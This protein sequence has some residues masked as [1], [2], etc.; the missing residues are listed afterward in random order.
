MDWQKEHLDKLLKM[1]ELGKS[2][3][4][5]A[6]ALGRSYDSVHGKIKALKAEGKLKE[7]KEAPI[8]INT[9]ESIENV[10]CTQK[11][12]LSIIDKMR[13]Q[14]LESLEKT[15]VRLNKQSLLVKYSR[16]KKDQASILDIS[17]VHV[18]MVNKI[19][20]SNLRKERT[21]YNYQIF[22]KELGI[23]KEAVFRIHDLQ[24]KAHNLK[25]LYINLMG[26]VITNDRIFDGQTFHIDR[27]VGS[28]VWDTVS[29]FARLIEDFK[30]IYE[31]VHVT[32]VVGNHGRSTMSYQS[33]EPVPNNF[34]YTLYRV[35][36]LL[37]KGD[38]RVIIDVPE[39][40]EYILDICG[41]KHLIMHGDSLRGSSE[42]Y[43]T[44]QVKELKL[45]LGDFDVLHMGHFHTLTDFEIGNSMLVKRN[46]CWIEADSYALTK[47]KQYSVPKQWFM[48]CNKNRKETWAYKIDL[49][50]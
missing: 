27:C 4:D 49:L 10:K 45:N 21:T 15:K 23:L 30:A 36:Q 9:E 8:I 29:H 7:I 33:E 38:N 22:L 14:L 5:I 34:E 17:D 39:T 46:G 37:F 19:F 50:G 35:L 40:R 26:D 41:W 48:G 47:F 25:D 1:K 16:K 18:G 24:S 31:K 42:T 32:T 44:K 28:Q 6:K 20:D 12:S 43:V 3:G 11:E 2:D 13:N